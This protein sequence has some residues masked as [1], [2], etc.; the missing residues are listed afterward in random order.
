MELNEILEYMLESVP[1][2]YD[3]SVGSFFYDLLYP[4]AEQLY[5]LQDRIAELSINT[6]A[7][8]AVGEYL[9][10]KVAEQGISRRQAVF[11]KGEVRISGESGA[12]VPKGAK[13]AAGDV[14]FA[15]DEDATIPE[16]GYVDVS[17]TCIT[18]GSMGNVKIGAI[19]RFPVTL[20]GLT[21]VESITDFIGGYD[22][23]SDSD[24]LERYLEKVSRPNVSGNKNHYIE[25][26]KEVIGVGDVRIIPLWNGNGTVKVII[27]DADNQPATDELVAK[28]QKHI[29]EH[30]PIGA[31]V[32]VV[33]AASLQINISLTLIAEERDNIQENIETAIRQ[34]LSEVALNKLYVSYAKIG[35]IILSI[36]GVDDYSN[37][38][39]NNETSN[40]SLAE[41]VIP[42]LGTVV[43]S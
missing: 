18:A 26:A 16:T 38:K 23:E 7:L 13:V 41:G 20:P 1:N 33:S 10:R 25:W 2:D 15:V 17:A 22:E 34:Y 21:A 24:L 43:I 31:N 36:S 11:S 30:K 8:T 6:F 32:T 29:D 4:V 27:T 37:L 14:L 12:P 42:V 19:N 40:I 5:I 28:V 39:M 35:G 3:V 9:D